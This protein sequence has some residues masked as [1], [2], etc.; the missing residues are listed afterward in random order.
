MILN[1]LEKWHQILGQKINYGKEKSNNI[2]EMGTWTCPG[3]NDTSILSRKELL[4]TEN[5]VFEL[6]DG[7][8][9]LVD[10]G[11]LK[12]N[13]VEF[14]SRA[15][16]LDKS[17]YRYKIFKTDV[18]GMGDYQIIGNFNITDPIELS[19]ILCSANHMIKADMENAGP[20]FAISNDNDQENIN[21]GYYTG[22]HGKLKM[23]FIERK[24]PESGKIREYHLHESDV[25]RDFYKINRYFL[26]AD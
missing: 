8:L 12:T 1:I 18:A 2:K 23:V 15:R 4:S 24:R 10:P 16:T 17:E 11:M 25:P 3:E 21:L 6:S 26:I 14:F 22:E 7:T 19:E 5:K 20:L 13:F 9:L